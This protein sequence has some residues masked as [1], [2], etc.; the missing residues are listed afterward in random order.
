MLRF[1]FPGASLLLVLLLGL[2]SPARA[3]NFVVNDNDDADDG[4]CNA[5]HCSLREAIQAA[6]AAAR[7]GPIEEDVAS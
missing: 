2:A 7:R 4:V 3:A 6:N 5:L 1:P